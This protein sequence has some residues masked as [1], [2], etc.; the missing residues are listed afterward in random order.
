MDRGG[1]GGEV[2]LFRSLG[3]QGFGVHS[4]CDRKSPEGFMQALAL[5]LFNSPD[6]PRL[7]GFYFP[8]QGWVRDGTSALRS[9]RAES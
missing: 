5:V 2:W 6:A 3:A 8:D 7:V 4:D 9:G 1:A